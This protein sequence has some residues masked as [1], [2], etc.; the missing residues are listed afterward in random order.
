MYKL[1]GIQSRL[2]IRPWE[3]LDTDFW[4]PLQHSSFSTM[5]PTCVRCDSSALIFPT[6]FD[7]KSLPTV[8]HTLLNRLTNQNWFVHRLWIYQSARSDLRRTSVSSGHFQT[9]WQLLKNNRSHKR[10]TRHKAVVKRLNTLYR[11][12]FW[13]PIS[14]CMCCCWRAS[15]ISLRFSPSSPL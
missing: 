5:T 15:T 8:P 11:I 4:L 9:C 12:F 14:V 7:S 10:L 3:V 1:F 13:V 2:R 6:F